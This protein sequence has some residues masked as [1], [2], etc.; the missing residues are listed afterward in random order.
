MHLPDIENSSDASSRWRHVQIERD[1]TDFGVSFFNATDA[2]SQWSSRSRAIQ[3]NSTSE[4]LK[5]LTVRL[6]PKS[7]GVPSSIS[8]V[9][10]YSE[11]GAVSKRGCPRKKVKVDY[12]D[13]RL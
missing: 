9:K 2:H 10:S 7:M 6:A 11:L 12:P 5:T 13:R 3:V 4:F 8:P 1:P